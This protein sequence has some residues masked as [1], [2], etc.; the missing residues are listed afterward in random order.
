MP[1]D[2]AADAAL[3][4]AYHLLADR[5]A[6]TAKLLDDLVIIINPSVNPD[7]RNRYNQMLTETRGAQPNID[8]QSMHHGGWWPGGQ[9]SGPGPCS[10]MRRA[11]ASS[12]FMSQVPTGQSATLPSFL[13]L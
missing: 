7:G 5:S 10:V 9:P 2:G 1:L 13:T 11:P 8:D 4:V 12:D 3:A 6:A